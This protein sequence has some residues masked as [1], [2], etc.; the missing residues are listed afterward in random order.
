MVLFSILVFFVIFSIL[1]LIHEFGHYYA[2]IKS[3]VKVEEFGLGMGKK[4]YGK[5]YGETEFTFNAVPFGG[6]VRMLGE[7]ETSKDPR[8]FGQA[9]LLNRMIITLAGVFMNFVLAI[10]LLTILFTIGTNP[11]LVSK[12]DIDRA[13]EKGWIEFQNEA[14][15]V[16]EKNQIEAE[17]E[18]GRTVSITYTQKIKKPFPQSVWFATTE[19]VRISYAV[20]QKAAE[21]PVELIKERRIPEGLAGPIGIAEVTHRVI[22][23]GFLAL[24]KLTALLSISLGV[25]NLLPIPALDG[26][27]FIFQ[28]VELILKPFKTRPSETI[29]NFVHL[30]GFVL[31]MGLLLLI[32]WNDI[33]RIFVL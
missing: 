21:I 28:L 31:L 2:A 4:L 30:G 13:H 22:P 18:A 25:M 32:T 20:L 1:I 6:F 12:Q 27:R 29:E 14:G 9:P 24:V 15:N 23:L 17:K 33:Y 5:K 10:G 8:S 3:G 26:G 7:E 11:I 19:T 16:L